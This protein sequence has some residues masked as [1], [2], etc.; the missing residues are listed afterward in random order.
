MDDA[1]FAGLR[2]TF[3]NARK[4][5]CTLA[6]RFRY[7]AV[8][9]E[10]PEPATYDKMV[11]HV[12]QIKESG[13]LEEYQDILMYVEAGLVGCYGEQWGGKYTSLEY[14]AEKVLINDNIS[15]VSIVGAGMIDRPGIAAKMFKALADA[16]IN[17][18][19][20]STSEIKI[21]CVIDKQYSDEAI[22]ALHTAFDL[23][24]NEAIAKV[25]GI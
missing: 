24:Q 3:A 9:H 23:D 15:K 12:M 21:S 8:G 1:F 5:G 7:D 6:L 20:I 19:M 4:N 16:N 13:L 25:Y 18:Q 22:K 17:I 10:N 11:S 14:K 2:G